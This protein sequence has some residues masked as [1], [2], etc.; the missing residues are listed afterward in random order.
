MHRYYQP[1]PGAPAPFTVNS[2]LTDP[3]FASSCAGQSGRCNDAWGLRIVNSKNILI[4]A[5]GLYSFFN[6]N[7]ATVCPV[8]GTDNCQN[9]IFSLEGTLTNVNV[10]CL[11]TVGA[12]N[13]ITE[14]GTS[15]ARYSDNVNVYPGVI[16]LFQLAAGS[17][18]G[19]PPPT[20]TTS[21]GVPTTLSTVVSKT[22]SAPGGGSTGW[23]FLG[24]YTDNVGGRTLANGLQ[25]PGGA[26]AMTI[27]LCEATCKSAGY[28]LAGV[29][30]SGECCKPTRPHFP[31]TTEQKTNHFLG[32]DNKLENGGGPAPDGNAQCTMTCS[33]APQETCGGPNR[34]D[35]YSYASM[36][37]APTTSKTSASTGPTQTPSSGWNFRG[38][39]SD[40][41]SGRTLIY[42]LAVPGGPA[43]MTVEACQTVCLAAGYKIAGVE[44]SQECCMS[45]LNLPLCGM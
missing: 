14:A 5:A 40:N 11:G 32:C 26:S 8:A 33:G 39:Y 42:G 37:A 22:T 19:P 44:Y 30:Y 25:V 29:E 31:T 34:L 4:Y 3:D 36:T 9:N 35:L 10:Y 27:E 17:G 41:V 13:M 1:N 28:N 6:N 15:L 21:T 12:I 24:C 2:A 7:V 38:C 23:T 18:G 45:S 43:A 20:T 16:A